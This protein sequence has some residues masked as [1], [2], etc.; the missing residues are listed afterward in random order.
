M[1]NLKRR[2][3]LRNRPFPALA[4]PLCRVVQGLRDRQSSRQNQH[5]MALQHTFLE[6]SRPS[7]IIQS[8]ML[9]S[10]QQGLRSLPTWIR[11]FMGLA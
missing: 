11:R 3:R 9:R 1:D 5:P 2:L 6:P 10:I 4:A 7:T 8:R